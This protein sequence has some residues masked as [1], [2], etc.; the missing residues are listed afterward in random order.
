MTYWL[1]GFKEIFKYK[2]AFISLHERNESPFFMCIFG[3]LPMVLTYISS[4]VQ[5]QPLPPLL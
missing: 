2:I 4:Q 1:S 3:V 5:Q